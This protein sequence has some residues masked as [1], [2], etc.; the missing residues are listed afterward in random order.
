MF[1]FIELKD[2]MHATGKECTLG[3]FFNEW[4]D[5]KFITDLNTISAAD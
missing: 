5:Q 1:I 3:C 2:W 4:V